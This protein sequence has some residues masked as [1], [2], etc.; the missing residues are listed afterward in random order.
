MRMGL[1]R[2]DARDM[3]EASMTQAKSDPG[4]KQ[5]RATK[6]EKEEFKTQSRQQ[7]RQDLLIDCSEVM[8]EGELPDGFQIASLGWDLDRERIFSLR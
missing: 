2:D 6:E 1:E 7:A 5:R 8:W 3:E 4:A